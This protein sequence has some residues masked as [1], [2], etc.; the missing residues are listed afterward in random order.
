MLARA[1]TSCG[2]YSWWVPWRARKAMGVA[3]PVV[4]EWCSK[5]VIGEAG[6][7]QGVALDI[8]A[9]L[10][11]WGSSLRPVPPITPILT[12]SVLLS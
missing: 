8:E 3:A 6:L 7:P 1:G 12:G 5:M 10:W 11:K 2:A 4:G 9:T